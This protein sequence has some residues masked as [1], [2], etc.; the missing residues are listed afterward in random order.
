MKSIRLSLTLYFLI[1][2]VAALGGV[3]GFLYQTM[4]QTLESKEESMHAM[5]VTENSSRTRMLED[6]FDNQILRRAQTLASLAQS[7]WTHLGTPLYALGLLSTPLNP[8]GDLLMPLWLLE[9]GDRRL[10][11]RIPHNP[12]I[13]IQFADDVMLREDGGSNQDYYQIFNEQGYP[14]Q[15]SRSM[16]DRSFMLDPAVRDGLALF[17]E[18]FDDAELKPGEPVRRVTLKVP[19]SSMRVELGRPIG[20]RPPS[21]PRR[22]T[23]RRLE[24]DRAVPAFFIQY[25][26]DTKERDLA[27]ANFGSELNYQLGKMR[28]DSA[29]TLAQ[30][31]YLLIWI[32]L[33]LFAGTLAGGCWL[34]GLGLAPLNRLSEAVSRVSVRDFRLQFD[35]AHL[36]TEL[37]PILD[38]LT[39]TLELL[40]RA[41]AREKQAAADISHELRT[42]LAA[43]LTTIEVGL[44]R[45][46]TTE[47]YTEL[48]E[49]CHAIGKQMTQLVERLLALARIDAGVD[50]L[51][52]QQVDVSLLA[53]QCVALV[54]PLADAREVKLELHSNGP[55]SLST[56]PDKLRE[57][58]TNL[59]HNA[60]EYNKP[61]GSIDVVV[62][63]NNGH[64]QVAVRDTGI[65]ISP[66][67]QGHIFERFYRADDS[68]QANGLHA[69]VGLAIVKGYLDLMGGTIAVASTEGQGST[70]SV[71][72]PVIP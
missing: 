72:L 11:F 63:R 28:E 53:E 30:L 5:L 24:Y 33:G 70:F 15:Q 13:K 52:S 1:L 57:V 60:I 10:A 61:H 8:H 3:L 45:P 34:V 67:A 54:R 6:M 20:G 69:G 65:G 25:G 29:E 4:Y 42:P 12:L 36:P 2:L 56:D 9:G 41:F 39:Q 26:S 47:H 44:R 43:L 51:R 38:R 46:R 19:V 71:Q 58:I 31:R 16:G 22:N 32:G 40:R 27:L 18:Q 17:G 66:Q 37:R 49:D 59:L 23:S 64:M 21:G 62:E 48:L 68:R 50:I 14:V 55:T 7:Q 35:A